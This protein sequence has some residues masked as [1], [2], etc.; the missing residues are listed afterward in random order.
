[1]LAFIGLV[2]QCTRLI[3]TSVYTNWQWHI[4]FLVYISI[5][6]DG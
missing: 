3:Q 4:L 5:S 6:L 2:L 1:M